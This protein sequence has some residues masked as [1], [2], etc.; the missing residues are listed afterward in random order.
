[1][2]KSMLNNSQLETKDYGIDE[3]AVKKVKE[4]KMMWESQKMELTY[5]IKSL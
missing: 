5:K 1:M 2:E 4:E 3:N